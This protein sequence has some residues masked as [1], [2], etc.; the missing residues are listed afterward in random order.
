MEETPNFRRIAQLIVFNDK[1][2]Q[3]V[4]ERELVQAW[5]GRG[6]ADAGIIEATMQT[7]VGPTAAMPYVH[8]LKRELEKIDQ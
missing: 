5:N 8:K 4:I 1:E 6:K 3:D 2:R 7:L